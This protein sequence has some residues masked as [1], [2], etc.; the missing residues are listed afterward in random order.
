MGRDRFLPSQRVLRNRGLVVG[1]LIS[2]ENT[3]FLTGS[4]ES[5]LNIVFQL[6]FNA[7][8]VRSCVRE[9]LGSRYRSGP[10]PTFLVSAPN[11]WHI[12]MSSDFGPTTLDSFGLCS[13]DGYQ[14]DIDG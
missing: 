8:W 6:N 14:Q 2:L 3:R 5:E 1:P 12:H 4:F 7:L 9:V 11:P 13:R 10:L